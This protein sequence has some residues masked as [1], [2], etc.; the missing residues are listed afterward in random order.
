MR[1]ILDIIYCF[2]GVMNRTL[3]SIFCF[4]CAEPFNTDRHN[5]AGVRILEASVHDGIADAVVWSG[6]GPYHTNS[7][8]LQWF[9]DGELVADGF[10]AP[11]PN[12]ER[13]ELEVEVSTGEVLY[14]DVVPGPSLS[15]PIIS[16]FVWSEENGQG[17]SIEEREKVLVEEDSSSSKDMVFR[18]EGSTEDEQVFRWSS[19]GGTLLELSASTV[20]LFYDTLHFEEDIL[21]ER[22]E[23]NSDRIHVFLLG[24]D[25]K[26]GT[27]TRWIDVDFSETNIKLYD[28]VFLP[29]ADPLDSGLVQVDVV[30]TEDG[31]V[32]ENPIYIENIPQEVVHPCMAGP[33]FDIYWMRQGRCSVR[34]LD[35]LSI[36]LDIQ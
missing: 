32:F 20:D 25:G 24:M 7:P 12:A 4:S 29:I 18:L 8:K 15:Q 14:A 30:D 5:L 19:S 26:G 31:L 22:K 28:E 16:R 36:V 11:V 1:L 9:I 13:Y 21:E 10:A 27:S 17:Y 35:G 23:G 34:E 3:L 6:E 2:V 33:I